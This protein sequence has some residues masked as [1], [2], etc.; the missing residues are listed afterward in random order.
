[1]SKR[2][3][4]AIAAFCLIEGLALTSQTIMRMRDASNKE[5]LITKERAPLTVL[6]KI[7]SGTGLISIVGSDGSWGILIGSLGIIMIDHATDGLPHG[8][9]WLDAGHQGD[10]KRGEGGMEGAGTSLLAIN[11]YI[12]RRRDAFRASE[13][14][15]KSLLA[16]FNSGP[17]GPSSGSGMS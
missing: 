14:Q 9:R 2:K 13:Y 12:S 1:M 15:R 6:R 4:K 5:R 10:V 3:L 16:P 8:D 17:L 11:A 7:S